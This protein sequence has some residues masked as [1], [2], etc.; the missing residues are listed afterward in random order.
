L[1]DQSEW[2]IVNSIL[3]FNSYI[4]KKNSN[5]RLEYEQVGFGQPICTPLR[6]RCGECSISELCPSALKE[7][8]YSSP[9]SKSKKYRMNKKLWHGQGEPPKE[10]EPLTIL[11]EFGSSLFFVTCTYIFLSTAVTKFLLG[12]HYISPTSREMYIFL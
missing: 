2:V 8:S 11:L 10:H 12:L 4:L 9:S 7:I 1:V 6:H 5:I 3:V